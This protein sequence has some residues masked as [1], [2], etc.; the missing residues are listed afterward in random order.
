MEDADGADD[1][2]T[3]NVDINADT[4][5]DVDGANNLDTDI[6][7]VTS[8][9]GNSN[10]KTRRSQIVSSSINNIIGYGY[11]IQLITDMMKLLKNLLG[12]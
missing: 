11:S 3:A 9:D 12:L 2:G 5:E 10:S 6:K 7:G 8:S 4:D 1:P